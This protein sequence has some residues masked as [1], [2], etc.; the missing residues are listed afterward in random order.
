MRIGR[1]VGI[2]LL[3]AVDAFVPAA[4][5]ALLAFSLTRWTLPGVE[6]RLEVVAAAGVVTFLAVIVVGLA[7]AAFRNRPF[8]ATRVAKRVTDWWTRYGWP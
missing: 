2:V 6:N 1:A 8:P 7:G 4:V 5:V 3:S